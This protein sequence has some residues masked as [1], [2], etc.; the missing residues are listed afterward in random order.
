MWVTFLWTQC[1]LDVCFHNFTDT[2]SWSHAVPCLSR[3]CHS[4]QG[5]SPLP[6]S[7][8]PLLTSSTV[9]FNINYML[10]AIL[11]SNSNL[12][13]FRNP[14]VLLSSCLLESLLNVLSAPLTCPK[15]NSWFSSTCT[16]S[17]VFPGSLVTVPQVVRP[18]ILSALLYLTPRLQNIS[19]ASTADPE[20]VR[21][22]QLSPRPP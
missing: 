14:Q 22:S 6:P 20:S 11:I 16:S 10:L 7:H 21:L 4:E 1:F 19:S 13:G 12:H 5:L 2:F 15:P 17:L 8:L 9:G 18:Q 3:R